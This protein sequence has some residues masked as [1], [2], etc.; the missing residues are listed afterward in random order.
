VASLLDI[1][2]RIRAVDNIK[3][4]TKAMEMVAAA[5]LRKAQERVVA[6]RPYARGLEEMLHRLSSQGAGLDHPLLRRREVKRRAY[7]VVTGDRGLC[8]SYNANMIRRAAAALEGSEVEATLVAVGRKGRDFFRRRGFD[9]L[10][11]FLRIGEEPTFQQ[12]REISGVLAHLYEAGTVDE[13]RIIYTE[14]I[15]ALSQRPVEKV[16]LPIGIQG[17]GEEAEE[18]IYE[19]SAERVLAHLVPQFLDVQVY[20]ALLEA[21]ASEHGARMTAMGNATDNAA[22]MIEDLTLEFNRVRQA[23]ITKEI[24]EIV[25]GAEALK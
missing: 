8:G 9:L 10:A 14:F 16:L 24:L 21:K 3:Q 12:A 23:S 2:R 4:V 20:H 18:Y 1:R 17:G 19:P 6:A 5:K 25:S 15:S 22:E 11:E 7:V 13:V